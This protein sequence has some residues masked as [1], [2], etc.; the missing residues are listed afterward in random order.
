MN[1][2]F[3]FPLAPLSEFWEER[4]LFRETPDGAPSLDEQIRRDAEAVRGEIS[5][6]KNLA[7]RVEQTREEK[8]PKDPNQ[9]IPKKNGDD[10][11]PF[12]GN[13]FER[14][15]ESRSGNPE[16]KSNSAGKLT[17]QMAKDFGK[18]LTKPQQTAAI[19][20]AKEA[21]ASGKSPTLGDAIARIFEI[22][23]MASGELGLNTGAS[24]ISPEDGSAGVPDFRGV[25]LDLGGEI[26][27]EDA[28]LLAER[29]LPNASGAK[30][31]AVGA[32]VKK[33]M[34]ALARAFPAARFNSTT[35]PHDYNTNV[36]YK[37]KPTDSD[38]QY[39][40]A[41]DAIGANHDAMKRFIDKNFSPNVFTLVHAGHLHISFRPN[42]QKI[43]GRN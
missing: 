16:K 19:T 37:G 43:S 34:A 25:P 9:N 5:A 28:K 26:G 38:H 31:E 21:V 2:L 3:L 4:R 8:T 42:G 24:S 14:Y 33:M 30:L 11:N 41:F 40:L 27:P 35:R 36:V 32:P 10:P 20:K 18:E 23:R 13:F 29:T 6:R 1:P 39:G 12:L 22:F 15:S 7:G 17:P